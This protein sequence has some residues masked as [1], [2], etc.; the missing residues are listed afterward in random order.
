MRDCWCADMSS[1]AKPADYYN[2]INSCSV[3]EHLPDCVYPHTLRECFRALKPG[4][5]IEVYLNT[6]IGEI[7]IRIDP[8]EKTRDDMENVGFTAIN[9]YFF[10]KPN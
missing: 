1:I 4:G 9:D 2:F 10:I 3:F 7:H 5:V 8:V 6:D